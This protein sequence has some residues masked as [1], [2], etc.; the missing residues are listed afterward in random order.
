ML[1]IVSSPCGSWNCM[2]CIC[3]PHTVASVTHMLLHP[4]PTHCCIRHP[5][6][7]T[8]VTHV[9]WDPYGAEF[10]DDEPAEAMEEVD[11]VRCIWVVTGGLNVMLL[12]EATHVA[13][14]AKG[15]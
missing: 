2:D 7:I 6:T 3:Y 8:Y 1:R 10:E 12:K 15:E 13:D 4:S 14:E 5:H 9:L 11:L